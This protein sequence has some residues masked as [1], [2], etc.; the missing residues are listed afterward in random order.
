MKL[1]KKVLRV[2]GTATSCGQNAL[3]H[4]VH[5]KW[6][7]LYVVQFLCVGGGDKWWCDL[8][9]SGWYW[10]NL[11]VG[12]CDEISI[13]GESDVISLWVI[14]WLWGDL[15]VGECEDLFTLRPFC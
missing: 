14:D 8:C 11:S 13:V 6:N 4:C 1:F 7:P 2:I 12:K 3:D 9:V 15:C 5:I 10:Y